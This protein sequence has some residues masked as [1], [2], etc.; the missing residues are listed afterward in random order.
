MLAPPFGVMMNGSHSDPCAV[1]GLDVGLN[2]VTV[3]Q[4]AERYLTLEF[5]ALLCTIKLAL[6]EIGFRA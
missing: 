1:M 3:K 2:L 5:A 4:F 6:V